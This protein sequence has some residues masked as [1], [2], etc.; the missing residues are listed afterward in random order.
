MQDA[1]RRGSRFGTRCRL[2]GSPLAAVLLCGVAGCTTLDKP[3]SAG[4]AT[5]GISAPKENETFPNLGSVPDQ[6]PPVRSAAERQ[7]QLDVLAA[8]RSIG[9]SSDGASK[10]EPGSPPPPQPAPQS[11]PAEPAAISGAAESPAPS[12]SLPVTNLPAEPAASYSQ[13]TIPNV[14]FTYQQPGAR[15]A[16]YASGAVM[17]DMSAV[18][19]GASGADA[20]TVVGGYPAA[21]TA[22]YAPPPPGATPAAVIYFADGSAGLDPDDRQVLQS[23]LA[24]HRQQ[25]G[26]FRIV[27]HASRDGRSGESAAE[28]RANMAMS[29]ARA[30]AVASELIRNGVDPGAV[31][32]VGAG[33]SQLLYAESSPTGIAAN[34]RAEIYFVY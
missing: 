24:L 28:Q 8:D 34:R 20:T 29:W 15:P 19:G 30:N 12:A 33:D 14:P 4:A 18:D 25:G 22:A 13:N 1:K 16:S 2:V 3:E 26:A 32:T 27:G 21:P 9:Q 10:P 7:E 23:V 11:I 6:A 31:Q 5:P 17:V